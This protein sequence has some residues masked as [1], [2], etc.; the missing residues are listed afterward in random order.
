MDGC[1]EPPLKLA[2]TQD[3]NGLNA[4]ASQELVYLRGEHGTP[5]AIGHAQ[6]RVFQKCEH[7]IK[8]PTAISVLTRGVQGSSGVG[9]SDGFSE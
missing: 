2:K 5:D 8:S 4:V 6:A 9:G 1:A 7:F 3:A